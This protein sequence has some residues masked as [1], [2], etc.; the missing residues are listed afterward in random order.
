ML[1]NYMQFCKSSLILY[2]IR[3]RKKI[4]EDH[5]LFLISYLINF[6]RRVFKMSPGEICMDE[7]DWENNFTDV[8]LWLYC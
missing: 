2:G 1:L 3:V 5:F 7:A 4:V 6:L 8:T